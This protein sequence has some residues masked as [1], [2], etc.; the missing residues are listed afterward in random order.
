ME[1]RTEV[2]GNRSDATLETLKH[3]VPQILQIRFGKTAFHTPKQY[4]N[5]AI[6]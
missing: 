3:F 1:R 5:K 6:L 4:Q 2:F